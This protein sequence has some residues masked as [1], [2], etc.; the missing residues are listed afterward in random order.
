[1]RLVAAEH[2]DR[3][4]AAQFAHG[5]LHGV[6]QVAVVQTVDE[7]GDDLRVGL[8]LEH[9]A[10]RLQSRAQLF[11]VLDDAVVHQCDAG[12]ARGLV[13]PATC[14]H[15]AGREVRMRIGRAGR[16]MRG[17]ARVRDAGE[18]ADF[19]CL[20]IEFRHARH[21][22]GA[23]E[24]ALGVDRDAAGVVAAVLEATQAFDQDGDDVA[25]GNRTDNAAH[26]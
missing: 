16:S 4:G 26:G 8:A 10:D 2:R 22:A 19:M 17:P 20:G 3:V 7:V 14:L 23:L 6:E 13:E 24:Y 15:R 11:V 18:G 5:A 21:A 9:V 25:L 12:A 1:M